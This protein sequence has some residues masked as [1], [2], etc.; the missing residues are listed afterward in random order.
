[1]D[2]A[3]VR[4]AAPPAHF[5]GL[6]PPPALAERIM[7]WQ[8]E[9]GPPIAPPH[10]TLKGPPGLHTGVLDA[11]QQA[12]AACAPVPLGVAGVGLF[13]DSVLYLR[14]QGGPELAALHAA[15]VQA[16]GHPPSRTELAGYHSHLTL[17]LR[18]RPLH[19]PWPQ[20]IAEAREAFG[21]LEA[22]PA[23]FTA[24]TADLYRKPQ[25]GGV[26]RLVASWRLEGL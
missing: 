10:V 4:S 22:Q 17:A 9:M 18:R 20:V 6:T 19:R 8:H 24:H 5:V 16:A 3:E 7:A 11:C 13:G 1:M 14:V 2:R 25:P 21:D 12:S 23:T 26:Y 15:L